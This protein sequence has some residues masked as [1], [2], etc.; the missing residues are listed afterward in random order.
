MCAD[1]EDFVKCGQKLKSG[2]VVEQCVSL[3]EQSRFPISGYAMA[4]NIRTSEEL[5]EYITHLTK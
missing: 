5:V 1:N 3:A 4:S 2:R